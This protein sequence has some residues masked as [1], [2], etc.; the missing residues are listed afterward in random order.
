MM[1]EMLEKK[2]AEAERFEK[3]EEERLRK[4]AEEE[5]RLKEEQEKR[6]KE[7]KERLELV[8]KQVSEKLQL[9]DKKKYMG[10]GKIEQRTEYYTL[11]MRKRETKIAQKLTSQKFSA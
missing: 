9:V 3:E 7:E 8:R 11:L 1:Q 4:Q 5:L 2:V 6:L 10:P